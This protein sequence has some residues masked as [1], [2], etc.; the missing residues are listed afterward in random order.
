MQ[1]ASDKL[2]TNLLETFEPEAS[3]KKLEYNNLLMLF[4]LKN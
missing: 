4:F 2:V 3:D 1:D